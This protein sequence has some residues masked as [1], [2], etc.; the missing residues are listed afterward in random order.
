MDEVHLLQPVFGFEGP[1]LVPSVIEMY[2][3]PLALVIFLLMLLIYINFC[4]NFFPVPAF[5]KWC[6]SPVWYAQNIYMFFIACCK[7]NGSCS[8]VLQIQWHRHHQGYPGIDY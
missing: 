4:C 8:T 5:S 3:M 6:C 7:C 2:V 1:S